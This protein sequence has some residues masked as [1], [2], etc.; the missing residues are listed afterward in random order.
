[1]VEPHCSIASDLDVL[2]LILTDRDVVG[3]VQENVSGLECR[4]G[5]QPTADEVLLALGRLVFE[6]GHP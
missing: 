3:V 6:L 1:V 4:V 2:S 5:E